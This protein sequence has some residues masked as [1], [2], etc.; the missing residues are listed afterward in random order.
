MASMWTRLYESYLRFRGR[1]VSYENARARVQ[2][3]A[4]YLD[5]IDPTWYRDVEPT[6]L[7]LASGGSCILG[8]LHG[9]FRLGLGRSQ[10]INMSSAPRTSLSPVTYGF[11]CRQNVPE[12]QQQRDYVL[13]NQAWR[14]AIRERQAEDVDQ[15]A[16]GD[17]APP[18]TTVLPER[19]ERPAS[20]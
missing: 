10:L 16:Q 2:R 8:Q 19:P 13:L 14:E 15:R 3:G 12:E 6:T 20:S 5:E 7:E 9:D 18:F 4:E 11:K 17:G 1:L